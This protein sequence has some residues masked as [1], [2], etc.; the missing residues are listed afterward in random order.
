[1]FVLPWL[2]AALTPKV[3]IHKLPTSHL[4]S[5]KK[6]PLA[7]SLSPEQ[8]TELLL[9]APDWLIY[10]DPLF[11][12]DK[13]QHRYSSDS[14]SCAHPSLHSIPC[15][16]HHTFK[17]KKPQTY[18]NPV[19]PRQRLIFPHGKSFHAIPKCPIFGFSPVLHWLQHP[20]W[21]S[22]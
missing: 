14:P 18:S 22:S 8:P 1:M 21:S 3:G 17:N 10:P 12:E 20:C 5:S 16:F 19:F 9:L 11:P 6:D 15:D 7:A 13:T 4:C 2:E